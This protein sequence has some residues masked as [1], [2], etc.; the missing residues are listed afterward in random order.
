MTRDLSAFAR[1]ASGFPGPAFS[2]SKSIQVDAPIE[3]MY[4]VIRDIRR[5][6]EWS[7]WL[8]AEPECKVEYTADGK[9][10]FIPSKLTRTIHGKSRRML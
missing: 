2:F 7:P 10:G 5:R 1:I 8:I 6:A 3:K 4:P 9:G